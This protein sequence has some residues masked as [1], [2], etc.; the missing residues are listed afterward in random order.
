ME[1]TSKWRTKSKPINKYIYCQ[2][3]NTLVRKQRLLEQFKTQGLTVCCPQG[4]TQKTKTN[5]VDVKRWKN[6]YHANIIKIKT[7]KDPN[8][9]ENGQ[10]LERT[11]HKGRHMTD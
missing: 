5:Q 10:T 1:Q 6:M 4:S 3:L 8:K 9:Y 11:L 7:N 2:G